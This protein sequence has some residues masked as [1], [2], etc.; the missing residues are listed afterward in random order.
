MINALSNNLFRVIGIAKSINKVAKKAKKK[1]YIWD[2]ILDR[3]KISKLAN[4]DALLAIKDKKPLLSTREK[5]LLSETADSKSISLVIGDKRPSPEIVDAKPILLATKDKK[6]LPEIANAELIF[7]VEDKKLLPAV[8][9]VL[10]LVNISP[11]KAD[12]RLSPK[13]AD[14]ESSRTAANRV[15]RSIKKVICA[16]IILLC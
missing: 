1:Q 3:D 15:P 16:K 8:N 12:D 6:S 14:K 2:R 9:R 4:E 13:I 5:K 7:L 11:A 10:I